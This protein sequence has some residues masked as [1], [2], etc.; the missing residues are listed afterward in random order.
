MIVSSARICVLYIFLFMH[1]LNTR[2]CGYLS[3]FLSLSHLPLLLL[4]Y[5]VAWCKYK[6]TGI[7]KPYNAAWNRKVC[8]HQGRLLRIPLSL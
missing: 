6:Y 1:Q 2:H 3:L 4:L 7:V 5:E 8:S